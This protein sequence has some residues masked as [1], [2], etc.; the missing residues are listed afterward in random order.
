MSDNLLNSAYENIRQYCSENLKFG[1]D[2]A[3]PSVKLHEPTFGADEVIASVDQMIS[4]FVTMGKQVREFENMYAGQYGHGYG[5]MNNSGS[6]A[7]LLAVAAL[8]NP[9]YKRQLKPGD[10]VIVPTLSWSTTVWP[11]I[12]HNLVP[13]FVDCDP[14]TFN[15]DLGKLEAAITP[16]TRALMLVHVYGNPINMDE[17]MSLAKKYDLL[18]IEDSCESMGALY[19]GKHVGSFGEI[20]TFSFFFSHHITTLEGGI[21]T[22]NDFDTA[23]LMRIL[24]AHGWHREAD[25]KQKYVDMYPDHDPRFIFINI[26]YNIRPTEVQAAMGKVQL[27]KL[28]SIVQT[29]INNYNYMRKELEEFSDVI[30]FQDVTPNS[31]PSWFGFCMVIKPDA[32][33]TRKEMYAHLAANNIESR[34]VIAGNLAKHPAL[35]MFEHK[36]SGSHE[37]SDYIMQN[38]FSVGCHH[39]MNEEACNYVVQNIKAFVKSKAKI[40]A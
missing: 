31:R 23:E 13:V 38:G 2:S 25:E 14:K 24:R 30:S 17:I 29:R 12:Q 18:V 28:E 34:P 15:I 35:D 6:S 16:K 20:G 4:T 39:A 10:E 36:N 21:C 22:T 11:L 37:H 3:K 32:G 26:G 7:N 40:L 33:F 9:V 19:N 8:S 27:P 5:I 1:F